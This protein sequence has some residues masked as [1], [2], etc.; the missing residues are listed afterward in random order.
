MKEDFKEEEIYSVKIGD[1][2]YSFGAPCPP[3]QSIFFPN[4]LEKE[5]GEEEKN[6]SSQST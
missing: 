2:V 5:E 3:V 1:A 6:D 4:N